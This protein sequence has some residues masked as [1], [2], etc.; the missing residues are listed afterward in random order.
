MGVVTIVRSI[1]EADGH[2]TRGISVP[3]EVVE[4]VASAEGVN[5][6]ELPPL[7]GTLDA[8]ALDRFV[9]SLDARKTA[10]SEAVTFRYAGYRVAVSPDGDVSVSTLE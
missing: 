9:A 2:I 8:D 7:G 1:M 10:T 6:D 4:E 5:P 3:V